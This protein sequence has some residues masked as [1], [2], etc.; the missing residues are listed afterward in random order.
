MRKLL[1]LLACMAVAGTA[2]AQAAPEKKPNALQLKRQACNDQA[3][4]RQGDERRK[5]VHACV[6]KPSEGQ[7]RLKQCKADAGDRKGAERRA[8]V[9]ACVA[10]KA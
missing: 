2:A 9:Q 5:F 4:T 6:T 8:F 3:G 7:A 10:R 1:I